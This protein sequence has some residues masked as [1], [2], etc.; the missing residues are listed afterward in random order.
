M[1]WWSA[2][3]LDQ[4]NSMQTFNRPAGFRFLIL[5]LLI[6]WAPLSIAMLEPGEAGR[7][8]SGDEAPAVVPQQ[9]ATPRETFRTFLDAMNDIKRGDG[10]RIE[11][12]IE[13]LDL[14]EVNPL[15]A[16]ERGEYLAWLLL[17]VVD[18]TRVVE[19][20]AIPAQPEGTRWTFETYRDGAL[21]LSRQP[22]GRWL[23]DAASL[24]Q[25]PAI[26]QAVSQLKPRGGL[27]DNSDYL[28]WDIRLQRWAPSSLREQVFLLEN[29]RWLAL[30]LVIGLGVFVDWLLSLLLR[31]S[32]A[33][34]FARRPD[35]YA[36]VEDRNN[37]LRPLGIMAMALVW[38]LGLQAVGLP[39]TALV[40]LL[41]AV[42]ALT[43][44]A[45][46][47]AA[48]RLVDLLAARLS[49]HAARTS[50]KLDDVL[51]PLIPRTLKIF[52]TVV[53]VVFVADNLNIDITGLLAGLGLG[54]LAFALAAKDMV[55]NLFGSITV[56]LDRTFTVGDWIV[57]D[58]IEGTVERMGFRSTRVR[59]FYNSL[60]TVPNSKFITAEV[61]N[62]GERRY[63][64]Y[65]ARFGLA[66]DTPREDRGILRGV[67]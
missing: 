57:V 16:R 10:K 51:L 55:Q 48:Y 64:R 67:A 63:R 30:L 54:G 45:A 27:S 1:T 18:R 37:R 12:A 8:A 26:Y 23:F 6:A 33:R 46:V 65:K 13:T 21:R 22:D 14:S 17:E 41:V 61:D 3:K 20:Q 62:M 60:V 32:M 34:W 4:V 36:D 53:G 15:V 19:L 28:P 24:R 25:L 44:L 5:L 43:S 42:K 56:L 50:N 66:Y 11:D 59:T 49:A 47:W 31:R 58:G 2:A 52:V 39:E 40:I 29:W 7:D 38:W 35:A 9:L